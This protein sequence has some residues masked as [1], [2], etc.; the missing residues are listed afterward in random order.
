MEKKLGRG[1]EKGKEREG[2]RRFSRCSD[3]WSLIVRELKLV[4]TTRATCGYRDPNFSSKLQEVGVFSYIGF[5]SL[6]GRKWSYGTT[7]IMGVSFR[8]LGLF[9]DSSRLGCEGRYSGLLWVLKQL[10]NAF[11]A[12]FGSKTTGKC[13]LD[14]MC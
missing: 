13:M 1:G 8:T 4:Y 6:K 10:K 7:S 9:L 12:D 2:K 11:R 5:F 3:D 14:F